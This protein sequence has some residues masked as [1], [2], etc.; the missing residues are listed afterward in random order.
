MYYEDFELGKAFTTRSRVL[1]GTDID[2]FAAVTHAVNPLFL[3]DERAQVAG[4]AGRIAP[5][6][7]LFSMTIGLCYQAGL[8]DHIVAMAGVDAM[9]FLAP[10]HPGDTLTVVATPVKKQ[11]TKKPGRGLVVLRH[12]LRGPNDK[13]VLTADV[14]YLI[15]TREGG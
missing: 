9:K 2:L 11:A 4:L 3:S 6:P 12:E 8:Y 7:L 13:T 14:T 5:G 1:T 15:C 10:V